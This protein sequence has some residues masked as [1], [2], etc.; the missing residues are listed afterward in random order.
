MYGGG[1]SEEYLGQLKWQ[2]RGIVMDTKLT[3]RRFGQKPYTH[4]KDDL[5]PGLLESLQALQTD[6]VDMWYMCSG[7]GSRPEL[8]NHI[9]RLISFF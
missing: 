3:P 1:S 9:P 6:K 8:L 7:P 4:K 5:K 2:E